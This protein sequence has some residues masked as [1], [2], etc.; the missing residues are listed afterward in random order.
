M[1]LLRPCRRL[2]AGI[3]FLAGVLVACG[4]SEGPLTTEAGK[5]PAEPRRGLVLITLDTTRAGV[6]GAYG[7]QPSPSPRLDALAAEGALFLNA[8]TTSP[9]TLPSHSSVMTGLFSFGHGV[10]RNGP[11]RLSGSVLTLAE[12]LQAQGFATGA[13]AGAFVL[14]PRFGIAQGFGTYQAVDLDSGGWS[15]HAERRAQEVTDLSLETLDSLSGDFF[16]WSHYFDPHYPYFSD[17]TP[18]R[19]SPQAYED[20]IRYM[21]GHIGRLLDGLAERGLSDQ[22]TIAVVGD[23]GEGLGLHDELR[24]S[25]FL[26][27][28]TLRVPMFVVDRERVGPGIKVSSAV[29]VVDLAPTLLSLLGLEPLP[30][31]QG[32]DLRPWIEGRRSESLPAFAES[33]EGQAALGLAP[34]KTL[35][36]GDWKLIY[37]SKPRLF[38]LAADPK[39]EHNLADQE[40]ERLATMTR[41]LV[42]MTRQGRRQPADGETEQLSA[43]DVKQLRSL[44]YAAGGGAPQ[45]FDGPPKGPD[46]H[47]HALQ[48]QRY[49]QVE[50]AF[51]QNDLKTAERL[52]RELLSSLPNAPLP[53]ARLADALH[54]QGRAEEA[55]KAYE[56]AFEVMPSDL[57]MRWRYANLLIATGRHA[58]ALAQL[59][60]LKTQAPDDTD[61]LHSRGA[62]LMS[63]GDL[64]Q[65]KRQFLD[66]LDI[67]PAYVPAMEA[68][69]IVSVHEQDL[70]AARSWFQ[71]ALALDPKNQR[72]QAQLAGL[73][74]L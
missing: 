30:D 60:R 2:A 8:R 54:R 34:L 43:E 47:E 67:A 72:L 63:M 16:L 52:L 69:G 74:E 51:L 40:P 73:S 58:E 14:D 13:V 22:V 6:L 35:V 9:L 15:G 28:S 42:N 64:R 46:L 32:Q 66:I 1:P 12:H 19:G 71:Q 57:Q 45:D 48:I 41:S 33:I 68:L 4:D 26:Y 17:H 44:G 18:D 5:S 37:S 49:N 27:D 23:H 61:I 29:R 36:D 21:D 55:L 3:C 53:R 31:A 50:G 39:E 24:H 70:A 25:Y 65:A 11:D 38:N 10:R 56:A 20:E 62:A 59:D 7:R